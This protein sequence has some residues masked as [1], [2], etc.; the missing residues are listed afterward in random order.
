MT[1]VGLLAI[2]FVNPLLAGAAGLVALPIVIHLLSRRRF[3]RIDWA[4]TRFLLEAEKENRRRVR[5]EQWLLVALRCLAMLLLAMVV[6]RPFVQPGLVASLLGS[7]GAVQRVLIIDDSASLAF[8]G[9]AEDDFAVVRAAATRLVGWLQQESAG[10]PITVLAAS[11]PDA[12]LSLREPLT[13]VKRAE[14][15]AAIGRLRA[16]GVP[17]RPRRVFERVARELSEDEDA[18]RCDI[19]VISDFQRSDWTR[20]ED[21][22]R[23]AFAALE[24]LPPERLRVVLLAAAPRQRENV[25][26][27]SVQFERPQTIAGLPAVFAAEIANHTQVALSGVSVSVEVDG[28]PRPPETLERIEPGQTARL[29]FEVA[30]PDEGLRELT[31]RVE[32]RDGLALDDARRIAVRVKGS[33][34]VLLVNGQPST[35]PTRDEAYLVRHALAPP[36]PFGSGIRVDVI[37]PAEIETASL[38]E[39][40]VVMLCNV[41]PLG[42]GA[43]AAIERFARGGGG[44]A[45]FL[46]GEAGE[47]AEFNRLFWADGNGLL[48]APLEALVQ[49]SDAGVGMVREGDHPVTALFPAGAEALAEG[50]R[51]RGYFQL[52]GPAAPA[53]AAVSPSATRPVDPA[54]PRVLARFTDEG[55]S[56]ALVERAFG[57]GRVLLM[58]STADLDWNDWARAVDGSYVVTLLETVQYLA[59]RD[60]EAPSALAGE[61]LAVSIAPDCYEPRAVFRAPEGA[62]EASV[63]VRASGGAV[64]ADEPV[65]LQGPVATRIGTYRA[66][67]TRRSGEVELRP[68][69]VNLDAAESDLASASAAEL[70]AALGPIPHEYLNA[71]DAMRQQAENARRE[72]WPALLTILLFVLMCEHVLAWWFGRPLGTPAA[73]GAPRVGLVTRILRRAGLEPAAQRRKGAA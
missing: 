55:G 36:G 25:A 16:T 46:G 33:L 72:L 21:R 9:G 67:L 15:E 6:A 39:Y 20:A 29:P 70:A 66:E 54:A 13:D 1:Q 4:A 43:I 41:P 37:D 22:S 10:D 17:A 12:P 28:A 45:F 42:A 8:R 52:R 53:S 58:A 56:P 48:P 49:R 34:A 40:D 5:F 35:D 44:V 2:G 18:L 62:D 63:E 23:S 57:K 50:V 59:R 69:C 31:V 51:F 24:S 7:R 73:A 60:E 26:V 47:P 32:A 14:L 30:F 64:A 61:R 11:R 65:R 27:T 71:A 68:L 38:G 3:R 19:Y